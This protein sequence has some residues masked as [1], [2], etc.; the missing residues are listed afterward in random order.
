MLSGSQVIEVKCRHRGLQVFRVPCGLLTSFAISTL[1]AFASP[2][3]C[4]ES[5]SLSDAARILP[6]PSMDRNYRIVEIRLRLSPKKFDE[7]LSLADALIRAEPSNF[8]GH[9]W[10]AYIQCSKTSGASWPFMERVVLLFQIKE[11]YE[12]EYVV[13]HQAVWPDLLKEMEGAGACSLRIYLAGKQVIIF[14]EVHDYELA[15]RSLSNGSAQLSG[16]NSWLPTRRISLETLTTR[17][18]PGRRACR[19]C[20]IGRRDKD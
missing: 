20:F 6:P 9:F 17:I 2:A 10:K 12:A 14:M 8:E 3:A 18:M 11:G 16:R 5:S 13:R 19:R 7:A 1:L 4:A 15:G